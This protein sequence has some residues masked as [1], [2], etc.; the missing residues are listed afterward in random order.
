MQHA[1]IL[2]AK[3]VCYFKGKFVPY[4]FRKHNGTRVNLHPGYTRKEDAI[5][6][7]RNLLA[8]NDTLTDTPVQPE[9]PHTT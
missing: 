5:E 1:T 9:P 2:A 8:S 6:A 7:A 4:V 3:N